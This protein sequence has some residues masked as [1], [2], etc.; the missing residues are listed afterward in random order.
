MANQLGPLVRMRPLQPDQLPVHSDM[1]SLQ[2][3]GSPQ[4]VAPFVKSVL[5]EAEAFM[6]SYLPSNFTEKSANKTSP[7][8]KASVRLLSHEIRQ[9]DL[10][11]DGPQWTTAQ[12]A[13]TWFARESIH[14]NTRAEGTA[15]WDEFESGLLDEHSQHEMEYTPDVFDAHRV[16][17]WTE[18]LEVAGWQ[19]V[20]L[21]IYEMAHHI[22]PPLNNRVFPVVICTARHAT[23]QRFLVV[24]IPVDASKIASA[25]YSNGKNKTSGETAQQKKDITLGQYVSIERAEVTSDGKVRWQMGTASD[26]KGNLPMWAQKMGVPGA[27]VKDVGLFIDWT[28]KK[29]AGKA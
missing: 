22:P 21:S 23:E 8:A 27:V 28:Q 14:E 12:V 16:L 13:E 24:Q 18:G 6:A 2:Q 10:P 1:A 11:K 9:S 15:D 3:T 19:K 7:P 25:K 17:D 4:Q 5:E 26:A 20:H 29:R